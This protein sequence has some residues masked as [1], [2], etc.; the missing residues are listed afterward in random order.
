MP[1]Q[2]PHNNFVPSL[3]KNEQHEIVYENGVADK[4]VIVCLFKLT[5]RTRPVSVGIATFLPTTSIFV[6]TLS[7]SYDLLF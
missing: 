6:G 5:Y 4:G 2:L 3:F 7:I 1:S